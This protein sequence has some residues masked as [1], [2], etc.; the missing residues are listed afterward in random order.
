MQSV[1]PV[2]DDVIFKAIRSAVEEKLRAIADEEYAS[3][4]ERIKHK[5]PDVI[6]SVS[7]ALYSHISYERVGSEI[8]MKVKFEEK[9]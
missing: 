4:C 9:R 8:L 2:Q 1:R 5:I 7:L 6:A 3:A